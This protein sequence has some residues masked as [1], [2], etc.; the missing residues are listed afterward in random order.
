MKP[1]FSVCVFMCALGCRACVC[2][3]VLELSPC[4]C[5]HYGVHRGS[6]RSSAGLVFP[7]AHPDPLSS[8]GAA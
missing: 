5:P 6:P 8:Q 1:L 7:A 4:G 3:C 2:V